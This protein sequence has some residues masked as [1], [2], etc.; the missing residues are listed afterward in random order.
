[1]AFSQMVRKSVLI[2]GHFFANSIYVDRPTEGERSRQVLVQK[3]LQAPYI[4]RRNKI[5]GTKPHEIWSVGFVEN[6]FKV[7]CCA[8]VALVPMEK[9]VGIFLRQLL[10]NQC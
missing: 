9:Y 2:P 4:F 1:M 5:M 8:S 7:F 6:E 10:D 3:L